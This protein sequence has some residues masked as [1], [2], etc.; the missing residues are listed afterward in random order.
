MLLG[1]V[2]GISVPKT[3]TMLTT[4]KYNRAQLE[5][6]MNEYLG[7]ANISQALTKEV[8]IVAYDYN[9]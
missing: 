6:L 3:V 1:L 8:L 9:S 2:L 7:Q 5:N 4:S